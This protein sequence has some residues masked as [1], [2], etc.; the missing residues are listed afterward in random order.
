MIKHG[1]K[2]LLFFQRETFFNRERMFLI[3]SGSRHTFQNK[4]WASAWFNILHNLVI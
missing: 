1:Q 2:S 3:P 4:T